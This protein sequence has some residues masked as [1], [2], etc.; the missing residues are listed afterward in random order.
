M[1]RLESVLEGEPVVTAVKELYWQ[2]PT[3]SQAGREV[4]F[5]QACRAAGAST[6][7]AIATIG[8][9]WLATD[10]AGRAWRAY[11]WHDGSTPGWDDVP[12]AVWMAKQAAIVH[13]LD[14]QPDD[15]EPAVAAHWYERIDVDWEE[16]LAPV[17]AEH[18]AAPL[19]ERIEELTAA[20]EFVNAVS[21]GPNRWCHRDLNPTNVIVDGPTRHLVDWDNAGPLDPVRDLAAVF[22]HVLHRVEDLPAVYAAYRDASGPARVTGPESLVTGTAIYLNFLRS[23]VDVL[24]QPDTDAIHRE[25]A[26]A[27]LR[28]T[29]PAPWT[30]S[31]L[32]AAAA[33]LT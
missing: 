29:V 31:H 24:G 23:Q 3:E 13:R 17:R 15:G 14:W 30:V 9:Q 21:S 5:T 28:D 1:Y 33:V 26:L 12:A 6:S 8:G 19:V 18:W 20:T 10:E 4:R 22:Q 25:F 11:A 7:T 2:I 27:A 16:A 32:Q